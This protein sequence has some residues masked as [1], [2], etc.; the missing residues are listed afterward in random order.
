M[1]NELI[2]RS[3]ESIATKAGVECSNTD[4]LLVCGLA[5]E[6]PP[7]SNMVKRSVIKRT[8]SDAD[9]SSVSWSHIV[10]MGDIFSDR[11]SIK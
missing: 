1:Q 11:E 4:S 8:G 2:S 6:H 10:K 7:S 9:V 5:S 3:L